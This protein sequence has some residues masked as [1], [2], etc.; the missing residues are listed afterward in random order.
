MIQTR[1]SQTLHTL[2]IQ[3][4]DSSATLPVIL[5]YCRPHEEVR[6]CILRRYGPIKYE[7]PFIHAMALD[8][9]AHKLTAIAREPMVQW[10]TEDVTVTKAGGNPPLRSGFSPLLDQRGST[11]R[12]PVAVAVID[13]GVALHPDL[14]W[15]TNR[16]RSFC[17]LINHRA[18]PYDDDGHGTHIAGILA[19]LAKL[20]TGEG[21][22]SGGIRSSWSPAIVAIKALDGEG[23]GNAS[24]ILAA[25]Q[26]IL[27]HRRYYRIGVV[28]LSLGVSAEDDY[29]SDPLVRGVEALT[30]HGLTVVAAAGNSGP[31]Q[32][33]I[34]SPGISENIITVGAADTTAE[35]PGVASFSSRGPTPQ[36]QIKPDLLAPG[37][38]ILSLDAKAGI[39][40]SESLKP[41]RN[42][43]ER[44]AAGVPSRLRREP[45]DDDPPGYITQSGTSMA[46]PFVSRAAA[47][48][49]QR[50]PGID[51]ATV[52]RIL[53]SQARPLKDTP[54]EAQG[55]GVLI[56]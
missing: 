8:L 21:A 25:M 17:D 28:N 41:H 45:R 16:I 2:A 52:K 3:A 4:N 14:L 42:P 46:A 10:V 39:L 44:I 5:Y 22:V 31:K 49:C 48:L 11:L 29:D 12:A 9:P 33:T 13:T 15:P 40:L 7:L 6:N 56:P 54:P 55:R 43:H 37:V 38:A 36:G 35:P 53:L 51:P 30:R 32:G 20:P 19:G 23:N 1:L 26:W 47:L 18:Q 50:F 27:N 34:S 24:D